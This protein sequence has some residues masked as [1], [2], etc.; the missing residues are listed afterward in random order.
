MILNRREFLKTSYRTGVAAIVIRYLN[1]GNAFSSPLPGQAALAS[2]SLAGKQLY[3]GRI[4]ATGGKIYAIDFRAKDFPGWPTNE[5]RGVILRAP[6][7]DLVYKGLDLEQMRQQYGDFKLVTG[8]DLNQWGCLGAPP[9]LKPEFYVSPGASPAYFGQPIALISFKSVDDFLA[10][11]SKL[12][13]LKRYIQYEGNSPQLAEPNYGS[14]SF[15]FYQGKGREPEFSFMKDVPGTD[16]TDTSAALLAKDR[17]QALTNRYSQKI[18]DELDQSGWLKLKSSYSTQSVDPMFL[19]PEN[20]LS[21][22]DSKSQTLSLVL[23]TQ[24]PQ[25]DAVAIEAFFSK[26]NTPPIKRIV[27]HCC[28]LG[29][30]FGGKDSSDFSLHL[31][32]AALAEPDVSHRIVHTRSDQFQGGLKRHASKTDI[33]MAVDSN[34]QF[35]YL[36]SEMTLDGGGQNNYSFAVQSVGARN[37]SG[38]YHFP[39]SQ[40]DA[41]ANASKNIPAGSMRGFGSFQS[42][43]ALECLIDEAAQALKMDPIEIRLKNCL[44]G[45]PY[46]QTGVQLVIPTHAQKVLTAARQS[47]LWRDRASHKKQKSNS[48]ILYGTGFAAAFKT[49]GKHENGCLAGVEISPNGM[50]K[51]YTPS[52]DMGNG[53]ATTLSLSISSIFGRPADEVQIGVTD[54]F[55]ALNLVTTPAK[56]EKEQGEL[57]LN[58][59]WTPSLVISS[60]ASTSAYHLR[61]T[62]LE[63]AKVIRDFGLIPAAFLL[64]GIPAADAQSRSDDYSFDANGFNYKDGRKFSFAQLAAAAYQNDLMTG[65]LVHGY[66]RESWA[67]A[68]FVLS[69]RSYDT[70]IDAL[71]I[72][73]GANQYVAVPRT[74]VKYS[75]LRSLNGDANRMSSYAAIVSVTVNRST[76]EIRVVDAE[77]FLDCGPPIQKEIVEG[78]MLGAFAMGIGQTLTEDLSLDNQS[79]GQGEFNLHLYKLPTA[80]EC[81]VGVAKFNILDAT[82]GDEPRG[83]SEVVFN[84]ISAA[85]VNALAD[86]TQ[87][88]FKSLPIRQADVKKALST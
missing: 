33:S 28:F 78:Q 63:A 22:Y 37:A 71:S 56:S 9:F 5:R 20:G 53:S 34:G 40:I 58:P 38:A 11:K 7:V 65:A 23:G 74:R 10:V 54:Y 45:N 39:R 61:H 84:P 67:E 30:G 13:E 36:R 85:I 14:S 42:S 83:M 82:Q 79:A 88:R 86:A 4:K 62:V 64:L 87:Y 57:S 47:S 3:E 76:G 72:R 52:V 26:A 21:W 41:V 73:R 75:P 12:P 51:L 68:S 32:I 2:Q 59:F 77:T 44:P 19:E 24:S 69:Q 25:E 35:Q 81:A 46:T 6:R 48:E 8:Q 17:Y 31:A 70:E 49:F 16:F 60:A 66:Y 27:V 1:P 55:D 18:Q 80:R 50:I 29:G 43:F 15:V